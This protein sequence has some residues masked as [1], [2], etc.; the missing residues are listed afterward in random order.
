MTIP[1]N[2]HVGL[3]SLALMAVALLSALR[4][5]AQPVSS[6]ALSAPIIKYRTRE[7]KREAGLNRELAPWLHFSTVMESEF[8]KEKTY[9]T[10]RDSA[11]NSAK[12]GS[13]DPAMQLNLTATPHDN[14]EAEIIVEYTNDHRDPLLDELLLSWQGERLTFITGRYYVPFGENSSNFNTDPLLEFSQ[15]RADVLQLEYDHDDQWEVAL[16][17]FHGK[18]RS[19][20]SNSAWNWGINAETKLLDE[21][22][23]LGTGYIS[24]LADANFQPLVDSGNRYQK[25]VAGWNLYL[26]GEWNRLGFSLEQTTSLAHF[27]ELEFHEDRPS[28]FNAEV[29]YFLHHTLELGFRYEGANELADAVF[30]RHGIELTWRPN[31]RLNITTDYLQ[32]DFRQRPA[33]TPFD[34]EEQQQV[35]QRGYVL[36]ASV[37]LVF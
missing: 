2:A 32:G 18:A 16:Y 15:T 24:N 31:N 10:H 37:S 35:S 36:S 20:R 33:A 30:K 23:T 25:A 28:A 5:Q 3:V 34:D 12:N 7:E 17:G 21:H 19:V 22:V 1:G 4:V 29:V 13:I 14:L 26:L 27:H 9:F 6:S 8:N 11:K